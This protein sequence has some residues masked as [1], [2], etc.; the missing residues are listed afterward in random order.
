MHWYN[1]IFALPI[2][3]LVLAFVWCEFFG[4]VEIFFPAKK[5]KEKDYVS[6]K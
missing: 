6:Y 2:I 5:E 3:V 4:W 1:Y